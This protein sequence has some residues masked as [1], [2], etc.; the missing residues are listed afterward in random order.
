MSKFVG[1]QLT[2]RFPWPPDVVEAGRKYTREDSAENLRSLEEARRKAAIEIASLQTSLGFEYV[3]DGGVGFLDAF[4]PYTCSVRGAEGGGNIDKY[5]GT[6]N[7]YYHTPVVKGELKEGSLLERYLYTVELKGG[8]SKAILP[9]PASLALA[10]AN[11]YYSKIEELVIAFAAVLRED[12]RRLDAAGYGLIQLNECF[13][14][15]ERYNKKV[16]D[17]F[18]ETF[19]ECIDGIFKGSRKRSCLYFHSGDASKLL[20]KVLD[21]S[22]T[23][24]GFDFQTPIQAISPLRF[25]KNVLLGLQ[26]TTRKLPED[27][28][29]REPEELAKRFRECVKGLGLDRQSE[30]FLCPSQD[31]DGLQT[32][33]QARRRLSNLARAVAL[34][35]VQRE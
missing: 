12:V 9:S 20:P 5:P 34:L 7:S 14:T 17:G 6:R 3:T 32:Y 13:L 28:L 10:S 1:G 31:Y 15:L 8:K 4:S 25:S 19:A 27:W 11:S 23:D 16:G 29:H 30:I 18:I 24:V 22:V 2:G 33:L 21:T 26:N 35:G